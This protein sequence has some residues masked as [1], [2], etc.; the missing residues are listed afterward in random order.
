MKPYA[1]KLWVNRIQLVQ[2]RR[3]FSRSAAVTLACVKSKSVKMKDAFS[4]SLLPAEVC[5]ASSLAKHFTAAAHMPSVFSATMTSSNFR[6]K[7]SRV[8]LPAN[9]AFW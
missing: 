1:F 4:L 6:L 7:N 2:P 3:Y 9:H 8:Y 5:V